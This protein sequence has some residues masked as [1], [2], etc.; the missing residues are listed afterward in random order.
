MLL[1]TY[2]NIRKTDGRSRTLELQP[3][4]NFLVATERRA[5]SIAMSS[6]RNRE[7]ALDAVQDAMTQLVTKYSDKPPDE[8]RPLFYRIL[9]NRIND[10]H[11]RHK[12]QNR[13]KGWLSPFQG[14]EDGEEHQDDPFQNVP[15]PVGDSPH[16]RHETSRQL[17]VLQTA[18]ESL[19][20]RQREAFIHRCW[21]GL[22]TTETA[23]AMKCSEGSVKTHYSRA[24]HSLRETLGAHW[25]E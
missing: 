13:V 1:D 20:A 14:R 22:S 23:T 12:I 3:L 4:E 17:D 9:N 10:L 2:G 25:Y 24:I 19:P 21:E 18:V 15:G 11:R 8:W 6:L 7:D 16:H 5:Y